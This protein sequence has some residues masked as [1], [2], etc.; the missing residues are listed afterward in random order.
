M[1]LRLWDFDLVQDP[2]RQFNQY[3]AVFVARFADSDR[4][5]FK[6]FVDPI[7]SSRD[8]RSNRWFEP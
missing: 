1:T 8:I 7:R 4:I 5:P 6:K 3:A 2:E